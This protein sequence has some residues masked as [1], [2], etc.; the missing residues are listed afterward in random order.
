MSMNKFTKNLVI[1][2][3]LIKSY[4]INFFIFIFS[5]RF[6]AVFIIPYA[7]I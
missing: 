1:S 4:N 2:Y 5:L 6:I 3:N 7:I